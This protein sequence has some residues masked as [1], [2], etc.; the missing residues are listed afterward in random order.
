MQILQLLFFEAQT[1]QYLPQRLLLRRRSV[2]S[3][4]QFACP[5]AEI[6][7]DDGK[8]YRNNSPEA[9]EP[10]QSQGRVNRQLAAVQ[11]TRS[12]VRA[13]KFVGR[14]EKASHWPETTEKPFGT[15]ALTLPRLK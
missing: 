9:S 10:C 7:K 8:P 6:L 5:S 1:K 13:A 11:P 14:A 4:L 15:V 2:A 3:R 12:D